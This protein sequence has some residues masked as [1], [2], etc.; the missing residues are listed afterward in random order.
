[1]P[2]EAGQISAAD[3][4][5]NL[6]AFEFPADWIRVSRRSTNDRLQVSGGSSSDRFRLL[7]LR[8]TDR[9][10]MYQVPLYLFVSST[11]SEMNHM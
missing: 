9:V 4:L 2:E 10:T 5:K 7:L 6:E 11:G 1:V 3:A 8:S